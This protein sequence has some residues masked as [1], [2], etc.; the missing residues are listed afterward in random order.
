VTQL[1]RLTDEQHTH[2]TAARH[3][4]GKLHELLLARAV[5][6]SHERDRI[7]A[8]G[9]GRVLAQ[10]LEPGEVDEH[11][12]EKIRAL[13]QHSRELRYDLAR[14]LDTG[15]GEEGEGAVEPAGREH[16]VI[17]VAS[18]GEPGEPGIPDVC[19][20]DADGGAGQIAQREPEVDQDRGHRDLIVTGHEADH[21]QSFTDDTLRDRGAGRTYI[22][23][24]RGLELEL[25]DHGALTCQARAVQG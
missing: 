12:G 10:Q 6:L 13:E 15:C 25:F 18:V 8:R 19:V 7:H 5:G 4:T 23:K 16:G 1:A 3:Q 24:V 20:D 2:E 11:M 9:R 22:S 21:A 17:A 14:L